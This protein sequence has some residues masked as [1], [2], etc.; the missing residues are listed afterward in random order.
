MQ[1]FVSRGRAALMTGI[2]FG[3][4]CVATL[5]PG[6]AEAATL[7]CWVQGAYLYDSGGY[8]DRAVCP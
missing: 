4:M 1:S 2:V 5:R 6:S 3:L 7:S 8:G